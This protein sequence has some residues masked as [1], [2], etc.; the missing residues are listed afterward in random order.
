MTDILIYHAPPWL[1]VTFCV[2]AVIAYV[3]AVIAICF[4]WGQLLNWYRDRR[5]VR[6][7]P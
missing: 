1:I 3:S 6:G 5:A 2:M 7:R 4:L